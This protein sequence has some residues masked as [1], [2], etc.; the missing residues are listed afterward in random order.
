MM[1]MTKT[2]FMVNQGCEG[3]GKHFEQSSLCCTTG[4]NTAFLKIESDDDKVVYHSSCNLVK[5]ALSV[6]E[7]P[8]TLFL[9]SIETF[10]LII[11]IFVLYALSLH[12]IF[13]TIGVYFVTASCSCR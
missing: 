1:R 5:L 13:C 6:P 7:P 8:T 9:F 11:K 2:F 12:V 3:D 4:E 10:P